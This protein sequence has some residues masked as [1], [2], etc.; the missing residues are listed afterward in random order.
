ML[1][2]SD[3]DD[4]NDLNQLN[5]VLEADKQIIN[6]E[7][8]SD[9]CSTTTNAALHSKVSEELSLIDTALTLNKLTDEK[10]RKLENL[11]I[12]RLQDCKKKKNLQI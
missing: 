11:L 7:T 2:D 5:A 10:L 8:V 6:E 1:Q 9:S 3:E 12:E 4:L